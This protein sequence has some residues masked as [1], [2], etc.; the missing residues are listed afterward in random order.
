MSRGKGPPLSDKRS[1]REERLS[2]D[3]ELFAERTCVFE[4]S[5]P[6]GGRDEVEVGRLGPKVNPFVTLPV[7][8]IHA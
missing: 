8:R 6:R 7:E 4:N 2:Q 5:G 1:Q 3:T